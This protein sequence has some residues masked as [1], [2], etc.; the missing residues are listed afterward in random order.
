MQLLLDVLKN[1][2]LRLRET[3]DRTRADRFI[4]L[5]A[6]LISPGARVRPP[7]CCVSCVCVPCS[8]ADVFTSTHSCN[9][10]VC[11]RQVSVCCGVLDHEAYGSVIEGTYWAGCDW[12]IDAALHTSHAHLAPE[13]EISKVRR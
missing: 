5:A 13:L 2:G 9:K 10:H 7:A 3:E 4:L 1:D 8:N 6:K 12:C 11:I